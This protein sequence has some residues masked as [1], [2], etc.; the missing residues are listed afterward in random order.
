MTIEIADCSIAASIINRHSQSSI[1]D[2]S[3]PL[4]PTINPQSARSH[5]DVASSTADGKCRPST[6][7]WTGRAMFG[8]SGCDVEHSRRQ[9][10]RAVTRDRIELIACRRRG[11]L[12]G[13]TAFAVDRERGCAI[14]RDVNIR[15]S[16]VKPSFG[17]ESFYC[18]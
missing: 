13:I 4:S 5:R 10:D 8:T 1:D 15:A 18:E 3:N 9:C 2:R 14:D 6:I 12:D 17:S 16:D 7:H 11:N